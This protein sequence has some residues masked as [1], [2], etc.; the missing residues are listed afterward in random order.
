MNRALD[1]NDGGDMR[2]PFAAGHGPVRCEHGNGSGF[3]TITYFGVD[4]SN[5]GQWAGVAAQ[6]LDRAAQGRLV[7]F[8]LN[9]QVDVGGGGGFEGF[10]D[11]ASRRA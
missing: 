8:Q 7:V 11:N 5:A 1:L 2:L 10:F 3:V 4:R 6:G 9:D